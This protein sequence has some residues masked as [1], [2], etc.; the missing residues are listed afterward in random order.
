MVKNF[1]DFGILMNT[2]PSL[3]AKSSN[4]SAAFEDIMLYC[5]YN[6]PNG[7]LTSPHLG[8]PCLKYGRGGQ[9][10]FTSSTISLA[11]LVIFD[12]F[13]CLPNAFEGIYLASPSTDRVSIKIG[14]QVLF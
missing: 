10:V 14:V 9:V 6:A 2:L 5:A 13:R 8:P 12:V 7:S 4:R 1:E 3:R 11:I